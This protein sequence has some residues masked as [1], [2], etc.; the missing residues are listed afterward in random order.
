[1]CVP[2][3]AA[4]VKSGCHSECCSG[5]ISPQEWY[6]RP[7]KSQLAAAQHPVFLSAVPLGP[8]VWVATGSVSMMVPEFMHIASRVLAM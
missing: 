5:S 3:L 2:M 4:P 8:M 7:Y 6:S 1:M